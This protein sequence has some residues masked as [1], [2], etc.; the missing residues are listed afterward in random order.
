MVVTILLRDSRTQR[1]ARVGT[2][3][4][5]SKGSYSTTIVVPPGVPLGDYDVV[6][7]SEGDTRCGQGGSL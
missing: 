2:V 6:A 7:R 4:A 5:D 3:A 1:E